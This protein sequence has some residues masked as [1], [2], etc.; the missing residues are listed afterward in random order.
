MT[1]KTALIFVDTTK[2][3]RTGNVVSVKI[4]G[5]SAFI[6]VSQL[7]LRLRLQ[8]LLAVRFGLLATRIESE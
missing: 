7:R 4:P 3:K 8:S 5:V 6:R 1:A 2:H